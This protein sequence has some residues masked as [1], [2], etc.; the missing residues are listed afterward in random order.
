MTF[1]AVPY[2]APVRNA[3]DPLLDYSWSVGG[4]SIQR[5]K[6]EKRDNDQRE[7]FDRYRARRSLHHASHQFLFRGEGDME[8]NILLFCRQYERFVPHDTIG[9]NPRLR[10]TLEYALATIIVI[11]LGGLAGWYFFL[12]SATS[13]TQAKDTARGYVSNTFDPGTPDKAG[14]PRQAPSSSRR[15]GEKSRRNSGTSP[16]HR[17]AAPRVGTS[18]IRLRFAERSSGNIFDVDPSTGSVTRVSNTLMPKIYE[19]LF[20]DTGSVVLRSL[21]ESATETTFSGMLKTASSTETLSGAYIAVE[22]RVFLS[23]ARAAH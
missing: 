5:R 2:Y 4:A 14:L 11:V 9:M 18:T 8:R 6:N 22:S 20:A 1:A 16:P 12:R 3:N 23:I 17:S 19:A 15:G 7:G 13:D 10:V 21:D